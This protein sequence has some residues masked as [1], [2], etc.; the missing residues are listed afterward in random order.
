MN[1]K[2]LFIHRELRFQNIYDNIS[3]ELCC[4]PDARVKKACFEFGIMI[5]TDLSSIGQ[6][7]AASK[8]LYLYFGDMYDIP[9][10]VFNDLI[11]QMRE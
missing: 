9:A 2:I 4:V 8:Q 1:I 10:F 5:P 3:G 11:D 7:L 6:L